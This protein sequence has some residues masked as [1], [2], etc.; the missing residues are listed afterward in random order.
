M[1][2]KSLIFFDHKLHID[3][4]DISHLK[5]MLSTLEIVLLSMPG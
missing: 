2:F 3:S 4:T 5:A 1:C